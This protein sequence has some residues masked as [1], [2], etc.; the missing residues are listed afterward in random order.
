M[1]CFLITQ[2][3]HIIALEW[4]SPFFRVMS[5]LLIPPGNTTNT[6]FSH[7]Y[8]SD[9][10][11]LVWETLWTCPRAHPTLWNS[12]TPVK[13]M[14]SH[15]QSVTLIDCR[16]RSVRKLFRLW[17]YCTWNSIEFLLFKQLSLNMKLWC[18]ARSH[19]LNSYL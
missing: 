9:K 19:Y 1:G 16:F 6:S 11:L 2:I 18:W 4:T 17:K 13:M 15:P 8:L 7:H 10:L 5:S 14:F 3:A 12:W